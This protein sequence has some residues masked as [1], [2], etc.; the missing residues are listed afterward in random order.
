[1]LIVTGIQWTW[2]TR[3]GDFCLW[4]WRPLQTPWEHLTIRRK[5][6]P[7]CHT[8]FQSE[9]LWLFLCDLLSPKKSFGW[10][11]SHMKL[12]KYYLNENNWCYRHMQ[13]IV[14]QFVHSTEV[15]P[16]NK[17]IVL[18]PWAYPTNRRW[19]S[20]NRNNMMLLP[21]VE[22]HTC[23]FTAIRLGSQV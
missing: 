23:N 21:I 8:C 14:S 7:K 20:M 19:K 22:K 3:G 1:M 4:C 11:E 15:Y 10:T 16:N 13:R 18:Q 6:Q 12:V 17:T 2:Q 9:A 5:P